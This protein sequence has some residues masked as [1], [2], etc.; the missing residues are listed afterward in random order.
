MNGEDWRRNRKI[1]ASSFNERTSNS[2]W[3]EALRQAHDM[4]QVWLQQ[5]RAGTKDTVGDTTVLAL[6]VFTGAGFGMQYSF[7]QGVQQPQPG[8]TLT[9]RDAL[10]LILSNIIFLFL[11]PPRVLRSPFVPKK[12]RDL[13]QATLD[14]QKYMENMLAR[15]RRLISQR[16]PGQG[17]LMSALVRASEE[18][19]ASE[20][21]ARQG[22]TDE[23]IFGNIFIYGL[24]GHETTANSM[25]YSIVLL[26]A[27]PEWQDWLAEEIQHVFGS[28]T[29][30]PWSYEDS[31]PKLPRCLAVM[32]RPPC[33]LSANPQLTSRQ[34]ETVRLYSSI[35]FIPR[36][37]GGSFQSLSLHKSQ[38]TLPPRTNV[39]VNVHALHTNPH[40][41]GPD[42]LTWRP[43]RW[44][45]SSPE[46]VPEPAPKGAFLP[47]S[48]GP[49][50]CP[51][52]KFAQVEFV[53]A[54]AKLFH[55]HR[56]APVTAPGESAQ[57]AR[58]R[59]V[60]MAEESSVSA[61]TLQ[62]L[63]PRSAALVWTSREGGRGLTTGD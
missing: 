45:T 30:Q 15:E 60:A 27:H 20:D 6:H 38:H 10:S 58:A 16:E 21:G 11:L 51:G 47:W 26:A 29:D 56:V 43:G 50:V 13:G 48:D 22:L 37:T 3:D 61:I 52:R 1:T 4:L 12:L 8:F 40:L 32:V 55:R 57:H 25:A 39:T 49:R 24:V 23:E 35:I 5:G 53:A 19:K 17:N 33:N 54:M 28:T 62:M 63:R 7:S 31:F 2:V 36:T 46:T 44:I 18:A 9:Y 14:F 34:Y 59:L 42:A 41:W